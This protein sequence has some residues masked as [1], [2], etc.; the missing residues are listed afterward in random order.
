MVKKVLLP[1]LLASLLGA[2]G[3]HKEQKKNFTDTT[4]QII[5][6]VNIVEFHELMKQREDLQI[7][8]VRTP[9]EFDLSKIPGAIN[10]DYWS[11]DF[12]SQVSNLNRDKPVAVYCAAGRRSAKAASKLQEMGF[13]QIYDLDGGMRAWHTGPL[14]AK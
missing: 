6:L 14:P 4:S 11:D 5:T 10:I 3:S 8:D 7:V 1:I 2:C 9:K 13:K 12:N